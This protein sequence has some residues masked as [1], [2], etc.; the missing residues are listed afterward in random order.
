MLE[1]VCR[2]IL[3][4][5]FFQMNIY[6]FFCK[7]MNGDLY[8]NCVSSSKHVDQGVRLIGLVNN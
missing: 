1:V 7:K 4:L 8:N 3:K 5:S 6:E 2:I